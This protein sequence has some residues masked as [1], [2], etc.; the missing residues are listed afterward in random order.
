MSTVRQVWP[1]P[2]C[3]AQWKGEEDK[4]DRGRCGKTTSGNGQPGV[5]QVPDGSGEQGKMEKTGCKIICGGP[6]TL[7]VKELMMMMILIWKQI[8][9][10]LSFFFSFFLFLTDRE[11]QGA[12]QDRVRRGGALMFYCLQLTCPS[13]KEDTRLDIDSCT[14]IDYKHNRTVFAEY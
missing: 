8:V 9:L 6:T 13:D 1:K 5:R 14:T 11:W 2:S 10:P 4:A 12:E 7:A 3:K